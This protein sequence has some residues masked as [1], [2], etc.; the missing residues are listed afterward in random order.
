MKKN[1]V[2]AFALVAAVVLVSSGSVAFA[3]GTGLEKPVLLHLIGVELHITI[4]FMMERTQIVVMVQFM[5]HIK[6]LH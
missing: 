1:L 4:Q 3:A 5:Q 2:K 6:L